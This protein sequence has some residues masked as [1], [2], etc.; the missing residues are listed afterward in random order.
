[1]STFVL[2]YGILFREDGRLE[3]QPIVEVALF[4]R[5]KKEIHGIYLLDSGATISIA[6]SHDAALLNITLARG[7][8]TIV[9]GIGKTE[10]LGYRHIVRCALKTT[11]FRIPV[12]FIDDP[13]APRILGRE[14]FFERFGILFDE[15][16]HR[17]ALLETRDERKHINAIFSAENTAP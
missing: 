1:M 2:P 13:S 9:R 17:T 14:G 3:T 11:V 8:K 6:P 16:K 12:V 4:G 10:F 7:R 15:P 5:N